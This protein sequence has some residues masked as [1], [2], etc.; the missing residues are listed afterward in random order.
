MNTINDQAAV[1]GRRRRKYSDEFKAQVVAASSQP[2]V[3]IAAVS[4]AHGVD[5]NLARRWIIDT[6]EPARAEV[7]MQRAEPGV[8]APK[9]ALPP[10]FVPVT[11]PSCVL[12]PSGC[13]LASPQT[14][15]CT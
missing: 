15:T 3:S 10:P 6:R 5:A 13:S 12:A 11:M 2:G 14:K 7:E 4:T 8:L 9:P 1:L